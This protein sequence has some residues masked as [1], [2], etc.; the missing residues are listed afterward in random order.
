[1]KAAWLPCTHGIQCHVF[2]LTCFSLIEIVCRGEGVGGWKGVNNKGGVG[3]LFDTSTFMHLVVFCGGVPPNQPEEG[4]R[5]GRGWWWVWRT[6]CGLVLRSFIL[7]IKTFC[8]NCSS[9]SLC[10]PSSHYHRFSGLPT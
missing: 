10:S 1:M 9:G 6:G 3:L 4:E 5:D 8:Q 2:C 7:P